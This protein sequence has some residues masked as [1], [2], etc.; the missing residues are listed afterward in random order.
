MIAQIFVF[1]VGD[2]TPDLAKVG[3]RTGRFRQHQL[4]LTPLKCD[5]RLNNECGK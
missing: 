4:I 1:G 2:R 5:L 3:Y